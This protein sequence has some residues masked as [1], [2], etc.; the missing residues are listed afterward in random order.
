MIVVGLV[1]A[2]AAAV[3]V[4]SLGRRTR[5]SAAEPPTV[6]VAYVVVATREVP[7]NTRVP[8]DAV[9]IKPFPAAY[10][11]AGAATTLD[12]V[13]DKYTTTRLAQDQ[14]VLASQVSAARRGSNIAAAVPPG[15][16]AVWL[17]IPD[18]AAQ[19][20]GLRPGDRVDLLL[21]LAL[22]YAAAGQPAAAPS[23]GGAPAAAQTSQTT[24][25]TLQ[26]VELFFLG[27]AGA[28]SGSTAQTTQG[29]SSLVASQAAAPP[30][31]HVAVVLLEPQ[32]A[33]IAKFIKDAGGTVDLA[34]RSRDWPDAAA[35]DPVTLETLATRFGF[36]ASSGG[37]GAAT[38]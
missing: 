12:Q 34:L 18:L 35:T 21:T 29:G 11:P 37:G 7:E 4:I 13:T 17:P 38:R 14:I 5:V 19:T 27:A 23:G 1:L 10:L 24:Q 15:K 36:R 3:L 20:G 26:N 8:A 30:G 25:L 6:Q 31:T 2:T 22:P 33:V 32:D 16:L 9:V 28:E